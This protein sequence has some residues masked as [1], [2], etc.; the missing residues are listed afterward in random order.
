MKILFLS[1]SFGG[2]AS[3]K[4]SARIV[5]ELAA[6]GH[7]V[8]SIVAEK[9]SS[10]FIAD[11]VTLIICPNILKKNGW[12]ERIRIKVY[13]MFGLSA[14]NSHFFWRYRAFKK[15]NQ[16]INKWEPDWIYARSTPIDPCLIGLKLR[17]KYGIHLLCHFADPLPSPVNNENQKNGIW[18]KFLYQTM[19]IVKDADLVSYGTQQMLD[20]IQSL[21]TF[22]FKDKSFE[23]PDATID[24][25]RI[26]DLPSSNK[27]KIVLVYL[28]SIYG[29][30]NPNFLFKAIEK[31]N[32]MG[33][34]SEIR[35]YSQ[36][37]NTSVAPWIKYM[38]YTND[39]FNALSDAS[40]LVDLDQDDA[41]PVFIS[42]KLKD[43]MIVNRPILSITP[44]NSPSANLL[45]D[46]S[47]VRVVRNTED[48]ILSAV[49]ELI[50][51]REFDYSD[52]LNCIKTFSPAVIVNK[53]IHEM[54]SIMLK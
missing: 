54:K 27:D 50:N 43:Y 51:I 1:Y 53:I 38:G 35:I 29:N 11:N 37:P 6:L 18:Y 7:H 19:K 17:K 28:G 30:R 33:Y 22:S 25:D 34:Y 24:T 48:Q 23:S 31:L 45:K 3:G 12:G 20:Y 32:Q 47:S 10:E 46:I 52:R 15:S 4:I 36:L 8:V 40:I 41:V 26:I 49:M 21:L 39:I 16:I 5:N 2:S 14:Y 13:T 44:P 9:N 42:S